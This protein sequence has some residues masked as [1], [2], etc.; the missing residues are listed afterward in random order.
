MLVRSTLK[1]LCQ[2][3]QERA[4][5]DD[6]N[7]VIVAA[8]ARNL[9]DRSPR[10]PR[11]GQNLLSRGFEGTVRTDLVVP[12]LPDARQVRLVTKLG[13]NLVLARSRVRRQVREL[14]QRVERGDRVGGARALAKRL[15]ARVQGAAHGRGDE[16]RHAV[17][18]G[19]GGTQVDTLLV[20][21]GRQVW[22]WEAFVLEAEV[23]VAL[24]VADEVD[25]GSHGVCCWAVILCAV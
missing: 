14:L 15:D 24:G 10:L 5:R 18:V 9:P 11:P 20:A 1:L 17:V 7:M 3:V 4:M 21:E 8:P 2:K 22:V 12:A 16:V 23:V 19:E 6:N 25:C 13:C